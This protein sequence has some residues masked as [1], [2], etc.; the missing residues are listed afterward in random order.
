MTGVSQ[1][2][3]VTLTQTCDSNLSAKD[4]YAVNLDTADDL[5]VDLAA[6][7]SK[8]PFP[9]VEGN[10]GSTAKADAVIAVSGGAQV[11]CGA[12]VLPGDKLTATTDG[13]WIPTTSNGEHYGAIAVVSGAA[14]DLI[15][16]I[17]AQGVDNVAY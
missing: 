5:N 3:P 12:A 2:P 4:G 7:S 1:I 16:V 8:F 11:K 9:L 15:P 14:N 6:D 17:V 10:D 13:R